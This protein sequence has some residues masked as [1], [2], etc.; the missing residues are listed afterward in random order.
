MEIYERILF[1]KDNSSNIYDCFGNCCTRDDLPV[2]TA[3]FRSKD[4]TFSIPQ[5]LKYDNFSA[6]VS[7]ETGITFQ[8]IY[9]N[10]LSN[11]QKIEILLYQ[12][13]LQRSM[14]KTDYE[15]LEK[16][17]ELEEWRVDGRIS[18]DEYN[19]EIN[20][21][22]PATMDPIIKMMNVKMMHNFVC[23]ELIHAEYRMIDGFNSQLLTMKSID[24]EIAMGKEFRLISSYADNAAFYYQDA[25]KAIFKVLDILS[26][27]FSYIVHYK[28]LGKK[29]P[30]AH[31]SN[32]SK[33]IEKLEDELFKQRMVEI[34]S[35]LEALVLIRNEITHNESLGR[36]RQILHIGCGTGE[37]NDKNIFYSKILFWDYDAH[38]LKRAS[39]CLGF[40][41]QNLDTLTETRNYFEKT[42]KLV[43][44][45]LEYFFYKIIG[46]LKTMG[47]EK[48]FIWHRFP[49]M[50]HAFPIDEIKELYNSERSLFGGNLNQNNNI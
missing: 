42:I 34:C 20:I 17:L 4:K 26:R 40:F 13:L 50:L 46:D 45:C 19:K 32:I 6:I 24:F 48:P 27:W 29:V 43:V 22:A 5:H 28:N 25:L 30:Q 41:T 3:I 18:P 16:Y 47:I 23:D 10:L 21:I 49:D 11:M 31:F 7:T 38:S 9:D 12:L 39:S 37:V 35:S 36:N 44:L 14:S 1:L 15:M 8:A 33:Q 2:L